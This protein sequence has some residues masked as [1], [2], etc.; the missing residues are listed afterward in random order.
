MQPTVG[1]TTAERNLGGKN[2][3][4][5]HPDRRSGRGFPDSKRIWRGRRIGLGARASLELSP[6]VSDS[7]SW[8]TRPVHVSL[9][10]SPSGDPGCKAGA[11]RSQAPGPMQRKL[12]RFSPSGLPMERNPGNLCTVRSQRRRGARIDPSSIAQAHGVRTRI[13]QPA[14]GLLSPIPLPDYRQVRG[15]LTSR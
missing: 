15:S 12:W 4:T 3:T 2:R 5:E 7:P 14:T 6:T 8:T 1:N 11:E 10:V 9:S 13:G